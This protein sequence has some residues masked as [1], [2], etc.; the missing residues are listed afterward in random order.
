MKRPTYKVRNLRPFGL[1]L[2]NKNLFRVFIV[3]TL[4]IL[5]FYFILVGTIKLWR[6]EGKDILKEIFVCFFGKA[7]E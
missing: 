4:F 2:Y 3:L 5:P 7:E 6:A 1:W